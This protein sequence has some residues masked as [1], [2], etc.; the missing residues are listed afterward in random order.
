MKVPHYFLG[1]SISSLESPRWPWPYEDIWNGLVNSRRVFSEKN[2][3]NIFMQFYSNAKKWLPSSL[4]F[5]MQPGPL[6]DQS[7]ALELQLTHYTYLK[8]EKL[9]WSLLVLIKMLLW[10]FSFWTLKVQG[11]LE[12][13]GFTIARLTFW[14]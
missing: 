9:I 8:P 12:Y 6:E 5:S 2:L 13:Q 3:S 14:S 10:L 7:S 11:V 1:K 4:K